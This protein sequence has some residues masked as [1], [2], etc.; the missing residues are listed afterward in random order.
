MHGLKGLGASRYWIAQPNSWKLSQPNQTAKGCETRCEP[1]AALVHSRPDRRA[2]NFHTS[3]P[4]LFANELA[5]FPKPDF[6]GGSKTHVE[7]QNA[8]SQQ[9]NKQ[10]LDKQKTKKKQQPQ[11]SRRRRT[12]QP[13]K[14]KTTKFIWRTTQQT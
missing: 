13:E 9:A 11:S 12:E 10:K 4:C 7:H 5:M 8:E 14:E 2:R 6:L 3:L 1:S